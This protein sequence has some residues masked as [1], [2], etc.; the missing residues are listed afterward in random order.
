DSVTVEY[1]VTNHFTEAG[2]TVFYIFYNA[3]GRYLKMEKEDA[4]F[5]NIHMTRTFDKADFASMKVFI[6]DSLGGMIPFSNVIE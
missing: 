2:G 4:A 5:D 3:D 6:W 1:D